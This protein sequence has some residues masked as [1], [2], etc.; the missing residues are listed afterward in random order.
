MIDDDPTVADAIS[1]YATVAGGVNGEAVD[2]T[3]ASGVD[4][5]DDLLG[6]GERFDISLVDLGLSPDSDD[7][8]QAD[9]GLAAIDRLKASR[10]AGGKVIIHTLNDDAS[11]LL[12]LY[13]IFHWYDDT[14]SALLPKLGSTHG[15]SLQE[16]AGNYIHTI[17]QIIGNP[18]PRP[19][20]AAPFRVQ[21]NDP[22]N[23]LLGSWA[24][25][26]NLRLMSR[27][28]SFADAAIKGHLHERTLANWATDAVLDLA[29]LLD[30]AASSAGI[31]G[32]PVTRIVA[33]LG[34]KNNPA[35]QLHAFARTQRR[36]LLDPVVQ[37]HYDNLPSRT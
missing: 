6:D 17:E 15:S 37:K 14:V 29:A 24:A 18:V 33:D 30:S 16:R 9:S 13:A 32:V 19:D 4:C 3:G 26:R 20:R 21:P 11:R 23:R 36:F 34:R 7:D 12:L 8:A 2:V 35:A 1:L 22:F 31:T 10:G 25:F 27:C 28:P 5:L